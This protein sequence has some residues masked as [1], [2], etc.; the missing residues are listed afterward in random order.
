[1]LLNLWRNRA[2][3]PLGGKLWWK[4]WLKRALLLPLALRQMYHHASLR[5]RGA[6]I[7]P[8][9]FS[10]DSSLIVGQLDLLSVASDSF[11]GRVEIA[12]HARI[13]IGSRVCINDGAKLLSATHDTSDPGWG[14]KASPIIIGDYAWI[15]TGAI[16][17]PGVTIGRGAVVGAGAVIARDVPENK[18]AVGNPARILQRERIQNLDYSPTATL[19]LFEAWRGRPCPTDLL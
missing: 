19:A 18:I 3:P 2:R 10:S 7:D 12:V 6:Q 15:C 16:I 4:C 9:S 5:S 8:S 13:Q 14:T 17:L 11:V 1:M